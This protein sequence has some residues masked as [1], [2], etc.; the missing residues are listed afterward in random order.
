MEVIS[1]YSP[2]LEWGKQHV[3]IVLRQWDYSAAHTVDIGGNCL[4]F[5]IMETAVGALF[6]RLANEAEGG[7]EEG[8]IVRVTLTN[9]KGETLLCTDDDDLGEEWLGKMVVSVAIVGWTPPTLNE[10]RKK[11]GAAPVPNG[12]VPWTP[13]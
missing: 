7:G 11:N 12:D 2:N 5:S 13:L 3:E 8:P 10:V 4:G 1:H 9:P 6:D